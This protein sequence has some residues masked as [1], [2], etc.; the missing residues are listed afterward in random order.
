MLILEVFVQVN[1]DLGGNGVF[2]NF[3]YSLGSNKKG[4]WLFESDGGDNIL[5]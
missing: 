1:N 2:I 5:K 3:I 4:K